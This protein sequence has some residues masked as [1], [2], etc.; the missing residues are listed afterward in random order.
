MRNRDLR[1]LSAWTLADLL[2]HEQRMVH[3]VA[4]THYRP[5]YRVACMRELGAVR[6]ELQRREA[7]SCG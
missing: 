5:A 4:C 2:A 6:E 7:V 1:N 3:D